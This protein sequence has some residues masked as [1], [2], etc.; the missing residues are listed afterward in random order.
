M[1]SVTRCV[2][3]THR[4]AELG[5]HPRILWI[6]A[7]HLAIRAVSGLPSKPR[8]PCGLAIMWSS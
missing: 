7:R 2:M 5:R 8:G 1:M 4:Q 6:A 3:T